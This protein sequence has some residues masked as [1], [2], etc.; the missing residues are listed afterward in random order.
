MLGTDYLINEITVLYIEDTFIFNATVVKGLNVWV[1]R[2]RFVSLMRYQRATVK[3]LF[4]SET[5]LSVHQYPGGRY[6]R[7]A[8][9]T[10]SF[11]AMQSRRVTEMDVA[12]SSSRG[13][14]NA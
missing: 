3:P 14:R 2:D 5:R 7:S 11:T 9:L 1:V 12:L 8:D 13:A 6:L 10:R 4:I